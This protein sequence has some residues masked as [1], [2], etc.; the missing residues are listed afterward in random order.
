MYK[1]V[2]KVVVCIYVFRKSYA[3]IHVLEDTEIEQ[4]GLAN[5][6]HHLICVGVKVGLGLMRKPFILGLSTLEITD[7]LIAPHHWYGIWE[8]SSTELL[9]KPPGCKSEHE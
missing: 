8:A 1:L 4:V 7:L 6:P 3:C 5:R 2:C 9:M